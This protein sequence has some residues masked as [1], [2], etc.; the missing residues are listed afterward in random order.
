MPNQRTS[1]LMT[2][3]LPPSLYKQAAKAAKEE[4]RTKSE[5]VREGLRK[6]LEDK[7]WRG[8][9]EYGRRRAMETGLK[10]ED[11]EDIV[12]EFRSSNA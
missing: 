10:P 11:I 12:D 7:R 3:S 8:I 5:L 9:L 4:G 6:Y 1:K 2:I